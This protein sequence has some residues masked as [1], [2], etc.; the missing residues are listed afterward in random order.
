[1]PAIYLNVK[2]NDGTL[3][4]YRFAP[5]V[6]YDGLLVNYLPQDMEALKLLLSKKSNKYVTEFEITGPG[7]AYF[8]NKIETEIYRQKNVE[9]KALSASKNPM[10]KKDFPASKNNFWTQLSFSNQKDRDI[11]ALEK[12]GEIASFS[13][14]KTELLMVN[15]RLF[16]KATLTIPQKVFLQVDNDSL[17]KTSS[18]LHFEETRSFPSINL[19]TSS[20][21]TGLD[22]SKL[23]KGMHT[24]KVIVCMPGD[25]QP[26][27]LPERLTFLIR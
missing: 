13:Q 6:S 5:S 10:D 19:T 20:F 14:S 22:T 7:T 1:V 11:P 2:Y 18:R 16:D 4:S 12:A 23:A 24:I 26:C 17:I 25:A 21:R 15:V 27:V 3:E 8:N 9:I